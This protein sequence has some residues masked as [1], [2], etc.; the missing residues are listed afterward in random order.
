[1]DEDEEEDGEEEGGDD[2]QEE[3]VAGHGMAAVNLEGTPPDRGVG[4]MG[5]RAATVALSLLVGA[6][7]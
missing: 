6:S 7:D 1:L 2:R 4:G 3:L 5:S